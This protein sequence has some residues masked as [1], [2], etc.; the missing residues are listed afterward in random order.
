MAYMNLFI[1]ERA[2]FADTPEQYRS[3]IETADQWVQKALAAKKAQAIAA[4]P[5][6]VPQAN[7]PSVFGLAGMCNPRTSFT[8]ST[9]LIRR[10]PSMLASRARFVLQ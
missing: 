10:R 4:G 7:S 2:D 1:R 9:L 8:R 6:A 5:I 3:E